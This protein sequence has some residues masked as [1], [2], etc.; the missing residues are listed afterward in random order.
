MRIGLNGRKGNIFMNS[1]RK[2]RKINIISLLGKSL[3]HWKS[4]LLFSLAFGV[5]LTGY[6][7]L[8]LT[9]QNKASQEAAEQT[10]PA[11][12]KDVSKVYETVRDRIDN[13]INEKMEY[14]NRSRFSEM[15]RTNAFVSYVTFT[16]DSSESNNSFVI[17]EDEANGEVTVSPSNGV[18]AVIEN[19]I[20]SLDYSSLSE[21]LGIEDSKYLRELVTVY[22]EDGAVYARVFF[23]DADSATAISEF[24]SSEV[25][26]YYLSVVEGGDRLSSYVN[27]G[28]PTT[29]VST[30]WLT[31]RVNDINNL[32]TAR[33]KLSDSRA[34]IINSS[35]S[36][37][38]EVKHVTVT[39][40][41]ILKYLLAYT[42][43]SL[44]GLLLL[45]MIRLTLS[46][47]VYFYNDVENIY[48]FRMLSA[49]PV[50][51]EG[52]KEL[53]G[54]SRFFANIGNP[55]SKLTTDEC[56][57]LAGVEIE[58][59]TKGLPSCVLTGDLPAETLEKIQKSLSL[60]KN[61]VIAENPVYS[62][63][64]KRRITDSDGVVLITK[65]GESSL[66][67][68][69]EIVKVIDAREKKVIGYI[70]V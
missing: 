46:E 17:E 51:S 43:G 11:N 18:L 48:G 22:V 32:V 21:S 35:E 19:K 7:Y 59:L 61:S 37:V 39:K 53:K 14:I 52:N 12:E 58:E 62:L 20:N 56:Y 10:A 64:G 36:A 57:R 28:V 38:S 8:Q 27:P 50:N 6:K 23:T 26:D 68:I 42:G 25:T 1:Y 69:D 9:K 34:T 65:S 40:K 2:E 47:K 31:D 60:N 3:V 5:L 13:E 15:T 67:G 45:L 41:M 66:R 49:F 29:G 16:V 4:I 70:T 24:I 55:S 63:E 54:L 44:I 33:Q 30:T